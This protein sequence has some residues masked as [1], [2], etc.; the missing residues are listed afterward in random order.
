MSNLI[1]Q[2]VVSG[3]ILARHGSLNEDPRTTCNICFN[4]FT[5]SETD[6]ITLFVKIY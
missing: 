6:T 5:T 3:T 1:G 2:P 4:Y